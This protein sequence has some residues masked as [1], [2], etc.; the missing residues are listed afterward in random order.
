MQIITNE[1]ASFLM[2]YFASVRNRQLNILAINLLQNPLFNEIEAYFTAARFVCAES[3]SDAKLNAPERVKLEIIEPGNIEDLAYIG[4]QYGRFDIILNGGASCAET[5]FTTLRTLFPFLRNGGHYAE[6]QLKPAHAIAAAQ[7]S[8]DGNVFLEYLKKLVDLRSGLDAADIIQPEDSFLRTYGRA[9]NLT[10]FG[11][12]CLIQKSQMKLEAAQG[13]TQQPLVHLEG[14]NL[15]VFI[16]A[17]LTSITNVMS[18]SGSLQLDDDD[19]AIQGFLLHF[20]EDLQ[21]LISYRGRL[22]DGS[23]TDWIPSGALAGSNSSGAPLTGFTVR[24]EEPLKGQLCLVAIG[25]F[26]GDQG[27]H[28]VRSG[29]DCVLG[30]FPR[31]LRGIQIILREKH[32]LAA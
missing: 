8:P 6:C 28:I 24:L 21:P 31:A 15:P 5:Q 17:W 13:K 25:A 4:I 7:S 29:Q 3:R 9:M 27:L 26:A 12:A 1:K 32:I 20:R 23:W 14:S 11:N 2:K 30:P 10:F 19:A 18:E 16:S 22:S